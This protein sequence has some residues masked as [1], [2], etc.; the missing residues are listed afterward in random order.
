MNTLKN[1]VM[2]VFALVTLLAF[3]ASWFMLSGILRKSIIDESRSDLTRQ[4]QAIGSYLENNGLDSLVRNVENWREMINGRLSV[5]DASGKV[6]ADSD[7]DIS[8]LDNHGNR[9]EISYAFSEGSGTSIRYSRS[10]NAD[11]LYVAK[12]IKVDSSPFVIRISSPLQTLNRALTQSR[13]SLFLYLI[14]LIAVIIILEFWVIRHFFHPLENIIDVSCRI[15]DGER[16]HFPIMKNMELQRLSNSLDLM[17][18]NMQRALEQLRGERE[19]LS[20][21]VTSMPIGVILLDLE[22]RVRYIN[23]LAKDFLALGKD[24]SEGTYVERILPSG[25]LFNLVE[26]VKDSAIVSYLELPERG[27]LYLRVSAIPTGA[28]MLLVITD[29]TE[30]RKLEQA[31]RTFIADASHEL[32][33]PLTTVRVTAE[34]LLDELQEHKEAS[35]YLSII[36]E[37]QERMTKL[38]DDL[39]LLSRIE[40]Q[41]TGRDWERIDLGQVVTSLVNDISR[42]PFAQEIEIISDIAEGVYV[43]GRSKD[44]VRALSNILDNSIKY[45][46]EKFGATQGGRINI[47]LYNSGS[48]CKIR[49]SDNGVGITAESAGKIFERFQRGDSH[50]ARG[51]WGK[52]GYGLGLSITKRIIEGHYGEIELL[53]YENGAEFEISLPIYAE[54]VSKE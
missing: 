44:L 19:E 25:Q 45:V 12:G 32:Q 50:R 6:I 24:V 22:K 42:H 31:R 20:R 5:I 21:I 38:V 1:K 11:L 37:Q 3:S 9:P 10:L 17:S 43:M 29:L 47:R 4:V 36:I 49:I 46:R 2:G 52:G 8:T 39:L 7:T 13:K 54:P 26:Q 34:Y 35:K 18:S 48:Y 30:E 40:S 27:D 33:T 15:A 53:R 41:P 28:G 16:G 14:I 51:D 23:E